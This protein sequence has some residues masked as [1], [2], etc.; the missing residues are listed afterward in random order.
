MPCIGA[1]NPG[2]TVIANSLRV[3][4]HL[5]DRLGGACASTTSAS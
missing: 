2:L 3:G 4:D 1:V 5:L